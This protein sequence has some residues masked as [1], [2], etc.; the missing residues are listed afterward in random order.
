MLALASQR[1]APSRRSRST[2]D[3]ARARRA[4]GVAASPEE[5]RR[6]TV[7][8]SL[9][10]PQ[11]DVLRGRAVP[12]PVISSCAVA[13]RAMSV[14]VGCMICI[15]FNKTAPSF[16]SLI[17][18]APARR[19]R[20][21][22]TASARDGGA[23][24]ER[25]Q[26]RHRRD[27][28]SPR[29]VRVAAAASPRLVSA[30]AA[31]AG[32]PGAGG[33]ARRRRRRTRREVPAPRGRPGRASPGRRASRRRVAAAASLSSRFG[34]R[35]LAADEHLQRA[36]RPQVRLQDG[37]EA[38]RRAHV[39]QERLRLGDLRRAAARGPETFSERARRTSR[40]GRRRRAISALG[41]TS[42]AL[43]AIVRAKKLRSDYE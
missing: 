17:W 2:R 36:A 10:G 15:S 8:L 42:F 43:A 37:L 34:L 18:P 39:H 19:R 20:L 33:S 41:F 28:A 9:E 23:P 27:G 4:A 29:N 7:R 1:P 3:G 24:P 16:V 12:S 14:A 32:S 35:R 26:P 5:R 13:V 40:G 25:P 38:P 21:L 22:R 31:R 30:E 11:R 6:R